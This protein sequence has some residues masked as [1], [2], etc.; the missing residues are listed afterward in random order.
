[1]IKTA[2]HSLISSEL[3]DDMALD[4][5]AFSGIAE[6]LHGCVC[7][8]ESN[9]AVLIVFNTLQ[10]GFFLIDK[11]NDYFVITCSLAALHDHHVAIEDAILDH[12][13]ALN[14]QYKTSRTNKEII[15]VDSFLI[16]NGL[17][18]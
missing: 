9:T 1:M 6:R 12:R 15:Q 18:R 7:R 8:D 11:C 16:F 10:C 2:D 14:T 17:Y 4:S 13:V 5:Y 3:S